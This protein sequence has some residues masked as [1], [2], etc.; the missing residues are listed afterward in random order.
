MT[1]RRRDIE[2]VILSRVRRQL[3]RNTVFRHSAMP[4]N[5]KPGAR[6]GVNRS[7]RLIPALLVAASLV[8]LGPTAAHAQAGGDGGAIP[9]RVYPIDPE[10]A[11]RPTLHVTRTTAAIRVDGRLDEP[12]WQTQD[13]AT[14]FITALPRDGYPASERTVVHVLFDGETLYVGA[15]LYDSQ[16]D[17][18]YSPGLEQDFDTHEAD[19]FGVA[20]D[21]FLDRQNALMFAINPAGAMYDSQAFSDSREVNNAWEGVFTA[22]TSIQSDGWSVEI[23]IPLRTFRFK[24]TDGEQLWG[25]NFLRR[26]R[27]LNEDSYWAPLKRQFRVHKMS[28]AGTLAGLD[29]MRQGRNLTVKPWVS[30]KSTAGDARTALGDAGGAFDAGFDAKYGVT[31]RLTLDVTALT[32]FSQVEVDQEQVNLTRFSLFFPEKRDFFLE[33]DGI[34]TFGDVTERTTRTGSGPRDFKLFYSRSV[35]LSGDRRPIPILGGARLSGRAGGTEIGFLNM[36]TRTSDGSPAENFAVAR[37]RRNIGTTA[38]VGVM[39]INR[40]ATAD[41]A[42][43]TWNR[44]FGMDANVRPHRYMLI[45]SY[46][47]A[48]DGPEQEGDRYSGYVQMAWRDAIWDASTFVKHVGEDFRPGVGFILRSAMEQAY[49]T[50]G[51]HPQPGIRYVQEL[52]PYIEA[53]GIRNLDGQLETRWVKPGLDVTMVDGGA[54]TF[55]WEDRFERLFEATPIAGIVVAAG[56]YRF[57]DASVKYTSSGARKLSGSLGLSR[58]TF[59][60]GDKTSATAT[61]SVRPSPHVGLEAFLQHND[62][63]LGGESE[64]A[65]VYG[66]RIRYA[67][68]TRFFA[69]AFVQYID[70][71]DE[72]VT[73]ARLNYIHAPLSDLFLVYTERRNLVAHSLVERVL[74]LKVTRQLAF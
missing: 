5:D 31:S 46:V 72:L 55:A 15:Y 45:N 27:R 39:L 25:V 34:F 24:A 74:T 22:R 4:V 19:L 21:T 12:A 49:A 71:Q 9:A 10:A 41:G 65:D 33:N 8:A 50:F 68:S 52:N 29:Q 13:S 18:L 63:S 1:G 73:N 42:T 36:Q 37:V 47:A 69:S 57:G 59:Y 53:S 70:A 6:R 28:R 54:L 26:I 43:G 35:G 23:A 60:D 32:D 7:A 14:D 67:A 11:P 3:N 20:F 64:R 61:A 62:L 16:P 66:G 56:D 40:Q 17:K 2:F 38:D 51:A 30:A 48:T 44:S 58:G